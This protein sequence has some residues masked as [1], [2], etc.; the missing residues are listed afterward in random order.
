MSTIELVGVI[1][2]GTMGAGIAEMCARSG[3]S[4]LI[5]EHQALIMK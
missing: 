3:S 2:G 4:V 1:G 5:L